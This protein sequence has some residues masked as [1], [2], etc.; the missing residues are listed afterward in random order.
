MKHDETPPRGSTPVVVARTGVANLAS[1]RAAFARLGRETAPTSDP[2]AFARAPL[3]VLPGVGAFG[4]AM[5]TLRATGLDEAVRRRLARGLPTLAICLGFQLLLEGSEEA[6]GLAGLGLVPGVARR[7]GEGVR[8]P[9]LGWN[10]VAPEADDGSAL[11]EEGWAC[12]ANSY[13]LDS[14]DAALARAAGWRPA[15]AE[16]GGAFVAALERG[17]ALACQFHP[18]LSGAWGAALLR[19]WLE[20]ADAAVTGGRGTGPDGRRSLSEAVSVAGASR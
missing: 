4:P 7:F 8:I 19:R 6:P 10:R 17:T 16:Y 5:E 20:R 2:E 1:V 18:E 12:F 3:A 9:Q 11:V 15:L 14:C 13:R